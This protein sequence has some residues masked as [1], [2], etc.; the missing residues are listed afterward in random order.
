MRVHDKV[1]V[2]RHHTLVKHIIELGLA[3]EETPVMEHVT[4]ADIRGK[5]VIGVLPMHLACVASMVTEIPIRLPPELR[6]NDL[7]TYEIGQFCG[8]P[9]TYVVKKIR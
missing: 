6:G 1:I 4:H 7:G 2:T 3:G 8:E 5:H 9:Q